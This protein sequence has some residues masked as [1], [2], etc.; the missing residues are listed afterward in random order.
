MKIFLTKADSQQKV[1]KAI[2]HPVRGMHTLISGSPI[3]IVGLSHQLINTDIINS[4]V[5]PLVAACIVAIYIVKKH[6]FFLI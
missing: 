2:S 5:L 1:T 6:F 3:V 4:V